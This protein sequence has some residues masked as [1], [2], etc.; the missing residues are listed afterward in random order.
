MKSI[1]L[2][3]EADLIRYS[4]QSPCALYLRSVCVAIIA[5]HGLRCHPLTCMLL[6]LRLSV[7]ST[8]TRFRHFS[9]TYRHANHLQI[10]SVSAGPSVPPWNGLVHLVCDHIPVHVHCGAEFPVTHQF[11][12]YGHRRPGGIQ[13]RAI[14]MPHAV[15]S[16]PADASG[17][18]PRDALA[19]FQP[20]AE[21][22]CSLY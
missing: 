14:G 17:R 2:T 7:D 5:F 9:T 20:S 11:L 16:E 21:Y 8:P 4:V 12:L 10:S 6:K 1:G 19:C 15:S 22:K 13:P 18:Y 3:G